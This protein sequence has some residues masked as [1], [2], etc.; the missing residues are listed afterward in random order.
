MTYVLRRWG[1]RPC[2]AVW[3]R[4][5][6]CGV[7]A[8]SLTAHASEAGGR[9]QTA[10]SGI[11]R[12]ARH[13]RCVAR[14]AYAGEVRVLTLSRCAASRV[15]KQPVGRCRFPCR[16]R[17]HGRVPQSHAICSVN[18]RKA[19]LSIVITFIFSPFFFVLRQNSAITKGGFNNS[20]RDSRKI[21]T[22]DGSVTRS[23]SAT[24]S[25]SAENGTC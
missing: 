20:L 12:A 25:L 3:F 17:R 21:F 23:N 13:S 16:R 6:S 24:G 7:A 9:F 18:D 5:S 8:S 15:V 4:F 10:G 22:E 11:C 14:C 1:C 2:A 19:E